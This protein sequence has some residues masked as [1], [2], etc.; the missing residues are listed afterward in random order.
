MQLRIVSKEVSKVS[1]NGQVTVLANC[2]YAPTVNILRNDGSQ[3]CLFQA[4]IKSHRAAEQG[5]DG[6]GMRAVLLALCEGSLEQRELVAHNGFGRAVV[7]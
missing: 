6:I 4:N 3:P 5:H 1:V 2:F 7:T